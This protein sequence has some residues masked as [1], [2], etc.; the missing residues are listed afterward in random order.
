MSFQEISKKVDELASNWEKFKEVND[1][2]LEEIETR[3]RADPLTETQIKNL[4]RSMDH[5]EKEIEEV[6][7]SVQRPELSRVIND[8]NEHKIK[9]ND[10]RKAF[11]DYIRKGSEGGMNHVTRK[12]LQVGNDAEGG[13]LVPATLHNAMISR[14]AELSP[15]R[16]VC[17]VVTVGSHTLEVIEDRG[18]LDGAW[19]GE[20]DAR[21]E[22]NAP[23]VGKKIIPTHEMYAQPRATQKLLDDSKINVEEWLSKKIVERFAQLENESFIRGDGSGCPRGILNYNNGNDWGE[24]EKLEVEHVTVESMYNLC[25][26]LKEGYASQAKFL[27]SRQMMQHVRLLQ[28]GGNHYLWQPSLKDGTPNT[29]LGMPVVACPDMRGAAPQNLCIA[30]GDFKSAYCIVDRQDMRVMRDPYTEKPFVKFYAT[31][32][33]GGDVVNTEAI[34]MLAIQDQAH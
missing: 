1:N 19:V 12:F 6:K 15:V 8:V 4:N 7:I 27:M 2:R 25:Y 33:V 28:D 9:E 17:N 24:I 14:I 3:G 11:E 21:N 32:R 16:Q 5:L 13:H 34:K 18:G 31:K 29:L 22:T 26:S 23:R 30:F 20:A 10:H